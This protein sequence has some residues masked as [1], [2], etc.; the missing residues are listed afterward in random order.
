MKKILIALL[1][2]GIALSV[3]AQERRLGSRAEIVTRADG[4]S[5][6]N[7]ASSAGVLSP[8]CAAII[9]GGQFAAE[10]FEPLQWPLP[11]SLGGVTVE[12]GGIQA[13][14]YHA[15][16]KE[17]RAIVPDL[18]RKIGLPM[19]RVLEGPENGVSIRDGF[20]A[21][22]AV[23]GL[24]AVQKPLIR[25]YQVRVTSPGGIFTGWAA[26]AP[27]SPGFYQQ[28]DF[29]NPD[30]TV[31]QGVYLAEDQAPRLITSA[32]IPNERTWLILNG[33]GFRRATA[34][35]AFISDEADGYWVVPANINPFG[36]FDWIDQVNFP[37]PANAHGRLTITAQADAMTSNQVFLAVK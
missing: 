30:V 14:L 16:P 17:I 4:L 15:G 36:R 12:I 3:L 29:F 6:V 18:P 5:V 11:T 33:A 10:A 24:S 22:A 8:G 32:P 27:T 9:S 26:I 19:T 37:L 21:A 31:V 13:A 2:A 1:C 20:I 25:W 35:L 7:A 23:E 28:K 34:A